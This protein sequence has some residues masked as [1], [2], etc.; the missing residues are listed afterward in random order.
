[1]ESAQPPAVVENADPATKAAKKVAKAIARDLP[2]VAS[3]VKV[4]VRE[5]VGDEGK[6]DLIMVI[7]TAATVYPAAG[8]VWKARARGDKNP[9]HCSGRVA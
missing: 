3:V 9:K 8:Y 7:G 6:I 1:M 5:M 2:P 4:I